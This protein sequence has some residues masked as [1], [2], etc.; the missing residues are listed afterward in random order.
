M[1]KASD[2]SKAYQNWWR[3]HEPISQIASADLY[4]SFFRFIEAPLTWGRW[5]DAMGLSPEGEK[6]VKMLLG[7]HYR[8]IVKAYQAKHASV[9]VDK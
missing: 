4:K 9:E 3:A 8:A 2:V 5:P 1:S 7:P 6:R